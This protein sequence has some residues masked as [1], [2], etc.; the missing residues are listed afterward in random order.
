MKVSFNDF[1]LLLKR[2]FEH[3]NLHIKQVL[4]IHF[5]FWN[6]DCEYCRH[7]RGHKLNLK[8]NLSIFSNYKILELIDKK[9]HH[10][11]GR[12]KKCV[13]MVVILDEFFVD[14][15]LERLEILEFGEGDREG[16]WLISKVHLKCHILVFTFEMGGDLGL[17]IIHHQKYQVISIKYQELY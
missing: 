16:L 8:L 7:D 13:R 11:F 5:L 6:I 4:F 17:L 3:P 14:V 10:L 2:F 1:D 9:R 15:F 12:F